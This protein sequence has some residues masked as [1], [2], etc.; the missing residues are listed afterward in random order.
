MLLT[1]GTLLFVSGIETNSPG[2]Q[3]EYPIHKSKRSFIKKAGRKYLKNQP[4]Q[5]NIDPVSNKDAENLMRSGIQKDSSGDYKG[6]IMDFNNALK[7][8]QNS[9]EASYYIGLMKFQME[10]YANSVIDFDRA[11][12]GDSQSV[13]LFFVRGNA[14]Y[15]LKEFKNAI[16]DYTRALALNPEDKDV[17][18]NRALANFY[19]GN[20]DAA[21]KDMEMALK[22]RDTDAPVFWGER[23]R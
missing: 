10:D 7:L 17:Y 8:Y 4:G 19:S 11:I 2:V 3:T 23:C 12:S 18:Y 5:S 1:T 22:Y 6:A 20:T 9:P 15:E 14:Y 13:E 16:G 21:C